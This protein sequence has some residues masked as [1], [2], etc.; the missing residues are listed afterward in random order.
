MFLRFQ[1]SILNVDNNL[2]QDNDEK[3]IFVI[4][5]SF[6]CYFKGLIYIFKKRL[7][8]PLNLRLIYYTLL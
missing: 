4:K 2:F 8:K 3:R 6:N 1:K 5:F 7:Y